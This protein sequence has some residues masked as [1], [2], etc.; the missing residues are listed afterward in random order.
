MVIRSAWRKADL[1]LAL[2]LSVAI[3][4]SAFFVEELVA[5]FRRCYLGDGGPS[6]DLGRACLEACIRA[7]RG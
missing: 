2:Q 1:T 6:R 4:L 5:S 3:L 7:R